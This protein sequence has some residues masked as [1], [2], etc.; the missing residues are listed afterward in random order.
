ML[1]GGA[2]GGVLLG[3]NSWEDTGKGC[4]LGGGAPANVPGATGGHFQG[5]PSCLPGQMTDWEEPS[6]HR[7]EEGQEQT[8]CWAVL[9]TQG[10]V[11][12][13]THAT[14]RPRGSAVGKTV[15][16]FPVR[17][18][19]VL[20]STWS[21]SLLRP[22]WCQLLCEPWALLD[23]PHV[24]TSTPFSAKRPPPRLDA[25]RQLQRRHPRPPHPRSLCLCPS[26]RGLSPAD[27]R[28]DS[29]GDRRCRGPS[30]GGEAGWG[31]SP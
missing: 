22:P 6:G 1:L 2:P 25:T 4:S 10:L 17:E 12:A 31:S 21:G 27:G 26:G 5:G 8:A 20:G 9:E 7:C 19:N 24:V 14:A 3:G 18:V 11:E 28:L 15:P 29:R 23:G 30:G 16:H 13:I